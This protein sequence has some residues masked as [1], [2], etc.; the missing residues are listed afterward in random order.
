MHLF[1]T[2]GAGALGRALRPLAR[3]ARHQVASPTRAELDL[4]DPIAV[5]AAVTGSEAIL[6]LATRIPPPDKMGDRQAWSE[7]DRLRAMASRILVDAGL[8]TGVST[9][10][11]PTVTFIY[12]SGIPVDESTPIGDQPEHLRSALAAEQQTG[13]FADTGRRGVVLRL[14]LLDGPGTTNAQPSPGVGA[15]LHVGDAAQALLAALT[16]P[17]G[18]YNVCRNDERIS[19]VRF[20]QATAWSPSH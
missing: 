10:I 16:A 11:Q 9:Y 20:K 13:R 2:G 6:H 4:F 5:A 18:I 1:V 7:N 17:S 12:P 14:G 3:A 8:A 19:N 15:T